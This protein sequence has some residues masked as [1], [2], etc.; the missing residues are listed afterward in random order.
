M[1]K[2]VVCVGEIMLELSG[3]QPDGSAR[4][5]FGGDTGNTAIYLSRLFGNENKVGY[6][7]RLGKGPFSDNLAAGMRDEGVVLSPTTQSEPGTPGLYAISTDAEGERSFTYWRR[8][9]AARQVLNGVGA[10][11]EE[12][13]LLGFDAL[14]LSGITLAILSDAGRNRL[15]NIIKQFVSEGRDVMFDVNFRQNLWQSHAPDI[16][17]PKM[18][19]Q[20]IGLSTIVKIGQDEA[21]ALFGT[22][23]IS[24]TID[25]LSGLGNAAL[26]I[27]DGA[28]RIA[29]QAERA[30]QNIE[31]DIVAKVVDATAAGDSFSAGFLAARL[32]G[33]VLQTCAKTGQLLAACVIQ[34]PGAII[35]RDQMPALDL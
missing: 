16:D 29:V 28:G 26:V 33:N 22:Q 12:E 27:T 35:S 4:F 3:V 10:D 14:Y 34:F 15:L 23:S 32:S 25:R 19:E 24:Q 31:F 21:E 8:D 5:G 2:S 30:T 20:V 7:T 9:A 18:M 13:F 1:A 6:L 11:Q 17:V